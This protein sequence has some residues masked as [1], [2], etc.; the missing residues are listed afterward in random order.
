[1]GVV[2]SLDCKYGHWFIQLDDSCGATIELICGYQ[3]AVASTTDVRTDLSD[4][5]FLKTR[6]DQRLQQ[7]LTATGRTVNLAGVDVGAV[8]KVKG[9]VGVY[10]GVKQVMLERLC[11]C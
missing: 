2:V 4:K 10:R 8:I 3:A 1:M 5:A 9:G 7:G 11:M 6:S